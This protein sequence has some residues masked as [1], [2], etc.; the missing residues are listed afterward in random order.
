M[1]AVAY[2]H[3]AY[4]HPD[5]FTLGVSEGWAEDVADPTTINWAER[6]SRAAIAYEVHQGHPVNPCETTKVRFGRNN[7]GR[8]GENL[9]ADAIVT[10]NAPACGPSCT[11]YPPGHRRP[12]RW[13]LMVERVDGF[14]MAIPGGGIDDGE[15]G[16]DAAL[17]ELV[18]ETG[19]T[20]SRDQARIMSARYVPD[21]R[22]S[23]EAWAV[24]VPVHI[25]LGTLDAKPPVVGGD[26]AARAEWM[27][28]T[29][30]SSLEYWVTGMYNSRIFP[31]HVQ[32]LREFLG[33]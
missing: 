27:G 25:H 19:L 30:W 2:T 13:L 12:C 23:D 26:D 16:L 18:E 9:M 7:M 10:V 3:V 5:V 1:T 4:T 17:R 29:S 24:T 6:Q 21:P 31:A 11:D 8:W 20:V 14:G 33:E 32:M 22:A 15:T 28:A